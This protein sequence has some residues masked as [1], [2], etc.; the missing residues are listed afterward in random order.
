MANVEEIKNKK[1]PVPF[2][3]RCQRAVKVW[4]KYSMPMK[5][6]RSRMLKHYENGW[7]KGGTEG[8]N[9]QPLNLIDRGVSIIMPFLVSNNPKTLVRAKTGINSSQIRYFSKTLELALNYLFDELNLANQTLRPAILDSLFCMGITKTGIMHK[10][11]VEIQ[12]YLHDVGQPY[13]DR[14]DFEDYIGDVGARNREEMKF[15]GNFYRISQKYV[16]DS[17]LFK[18]WDSLKSQ[19]KIYGDENS[20]DYISKGDYGYEFDMREIHPTFELIDLWLPEEDIIITIPKEGEGSQILRVVEWEGPEGGPFDTL[21]YKQFPGSCVCIPPVY[22]WFDVNKTI[23]VIVSKMRDMCEREKT[24]GIFDKSAEEDAEAVKNASHGDMIG[25]NGG[26][27]TVKELTFGGFNEQ[28]LPFLNFLLY[29]Y[30]ISGPNLNITGGREAMAGTLGQEQILMSNALREL[31][32]M[33]GQVNNF[34]KSITRK[35]AYFLWESPLKSIP[36]SR[37]VAGMKIDEVFSQDTK[38]GDFVDY[39]IDLI[40]YSMTKMNPDALYQKLIQ[41]IAQVVVPTA[42]IGAMQGATPRVDELVKECAAYLNINVDGWYDSVVPQS[43][44]MGPYQPSGTGQ[45]MADNRVPQAAQSGA[46]KMA[47]LGQYS[48]RNGSAG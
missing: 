3:S 29:Q 13:C 23:N 28:S 19:M 46:S 1:V 45:G 6:C 31:D 18:H 41:L 4:Q 11:E 16:R 20:P 8:R 47:N 15:E 43:Y 34:V 27:D 14:V 36:V 10:Y 37:E 12:G 26:G 30:A 7:F 32:D 5:K 24:V 17:G 2:V 38:E 9:P 33:A 44:E 35:L 40:P 48:A 39:N 25:I 22:T 21:G 42:N